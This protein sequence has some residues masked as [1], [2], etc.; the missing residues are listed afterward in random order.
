MCQWTIRSACILAFLGFPALGFSQS[1]DVRGVHDPVL[2]RQNDTYY[3]FSSGPGVP[4]HRSKDLLHWERAGR[5]FAEDVPEWA[6]TE[7]PQARDVWAPDISFYRGQYQ[8][9]YSISTLGSRRSCIGLATNRTLDPTSANYGWVDQGKVLETFPE[10]ADYNAIDPNFVLDQEG[11]PW[12]VFGSY[13]S[14]IKLTGLDPQTGEPPA[15][16]PGPRALAARPR[17]KAIEGA[18]LVHKKDHYYL[19]VSFDRCGRGIAS[20]YRIMVGRSPDITGPYVDIDGRPMLEGGGTPLLAGHDEC[21]G[22]G[23]NGILLGADG[24]WLVHHM[25]D[26]GAKGVPTLQIRPLHWSSN[27]WPVVGEPVNEATLARPTIQQPDLLGAWKHSVN[28]GAYEYFVLLPDGRM[29]TAVDEASW[30]LDGSRLR[31]RW[32]DPGAPE[33]AWIDTCFLAPDG[34]SYVGRNQLGLVI[35]GIR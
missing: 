21:R 12:L 2:I 13:W 17:E 14:G 24:D 6:R 33:G 4:I 23:H 25:Y 26:A 9:Y 16:D 35:R 32:P 30:T 7:V 5:V 11:R 8:L 29:N 22:P 27:G 18:F 20:N 15:G 19:F 10:T 34:K 31:L 28:F 3:L 1:G